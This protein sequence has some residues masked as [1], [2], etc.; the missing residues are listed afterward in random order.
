MGSSTLP[1]SV[2]FHELPGELKPIVRHLQSRY[3]SRL[4]EYR[5][6]RYGTAITLGSDRIGIR[7]TLDFGGR[8][9]RVSLVRLDAGALPRYPLSLAE[10]PA[11]DFV[12]LEDAIE[13]F[14]PAPHA[15]VEQHSATPRVRLNSA[16]QFLD[17]LLPRIIAGQANVF[18]D[19][20]ILQKVHARATR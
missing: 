8:E 14:G 10:Q 7:L 1:T 15:G 6:D 3:V 12:D 19:Q 17:S 20:R 11:L 13:V 5:R 9:F 2:P 18:E 16:T 4:V